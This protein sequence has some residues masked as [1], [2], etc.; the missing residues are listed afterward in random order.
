MANGQYMK[1]K[2]RLIV[3]AL[4][5][6]GF[7]AN[8]WL[9]H[10]IDQNVVAAQRDELTIGKLHLQSCEI[11]KRS[12]RN[13]LAGYCT[14]FPVSENRADA[15]SRKISLKVAIVKSTS[16]KPDVDMVVFLDGGPG[17]SAIND[18]PAVSDAFTTLRKQHHILLVD[19]RGTGGSNALD[20]PKT[21]AFGKSL[22][23]KLA[24]EQYPPEQFKE[25]LRKCITELQDKADPR[26]Y[27]T[28]DA[29]T[30][31]EEIRSALDDSQKNIDNKHI[32]ITFDLIGVSY[33]TRVAQQY[34]SRYPAAVRSIVLDSPVPNSLVLG[35]EHARALEDA[36]KAQLTACN[37]T[38]ACQQKFGDAFANLHTLRDRLRDKPVT[39]E[40]RDPNTFELSERPLSASAFAGLVRLY[41]YNP[42]TSALLPLMTHDALHGNYAPLLG[43]VQLVTEGIGDSINTG[44]GLSVICTE[45]ADL[46]KPRP[47]DKDTLLGN[48][49]IDLYQQACPVWPHG[50]R[51]AHFHDVFKTAAPVLILSGEYD[52]VTPPRYAQAIAYELDNVRVLNLRGQGHAVMNTRCIPELLE[53]FVNTLQPKTLDANCLDSLSAIPMFVDYNGAAP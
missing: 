40:T 2:L 37:T 44:V 47:E 26:F 11:G 43:Q 45:D 53:K 48:S 1:L 23:D 27:S 20:C 42:I 17:G 39:V 32:S 36:L 49:L 38:P 29:V 31:L 14:Q 21:E 7:A 33:G 9:H 13:T 30:D 22:L 41:A 35:S 24:G 12:G 28:T 15:H 34:A 4:L 6:V 50:E 51:P 52:P 46:L 10:P 5:L 8:K 3:A 16:A 18:Y 25:L 19:Q